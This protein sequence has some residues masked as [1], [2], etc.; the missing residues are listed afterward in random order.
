MG[1]SDQTQQRCPRNLGMDRDLSIADLH[2][3]DEGEG[4]EFEPP[5]QF[6]DLLQSAAIELLND[7]GCTSTGIEVSTS[8]IETIVRPS[9]LPLKQT[10]GCRLRTH[11][12]SLI[13]IGIER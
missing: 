2:A 12:S 4:S 10:D 9:S 8:K 11:A 5:A 3:S 7:T 13:E 1:I 6:S